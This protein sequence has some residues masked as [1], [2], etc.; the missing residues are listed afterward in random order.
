MGA[1]TPHP[2]QSKGQRTG[3]PR[4]GAKVRGHLE[5]LP[6]GCMSGGA[7]PSD[8]S[9][10]AATRPSCGRRSL[11][12]P[13]R[14]CSSKRYGDAGAQE[15]SGRP[16]RGL[17]SFGPKSPRP[18]KTARRPKG[19]TAAGH[20]QPSL[21][22]R[23]KRPGRR[24]RLCRRREGPGQGGTTRGRSRRGRMTH[25]TSRRTPDKVPASQR[26]FPDQ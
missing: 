25:R 12:G 14:G 17:D 2:P 22:L 19:P 26:T 21:L 11:S 1:N 23:H 24:R 4:T 18:R 7:S 8:E 16:D 9:D 15:R 10:R 20:E 3:K 6:S 13:P 5:T